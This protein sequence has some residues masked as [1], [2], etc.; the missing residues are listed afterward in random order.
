MK[1]ISFTIFL[2]SNFRKFL[3]NC[4]LHEKNGWNH[5]TLYEQSVVECFFV[6]T[7]TLDTTRTGL[8]RTCGRLRKGLVRPYIFRTTMHSPGDLEPFCKPYS[9]CKRLST[10]GL[11]GWRLTRGT[12][13]WSRKIEIEKKEMP[14]Y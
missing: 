1:V 12:M 13:S 3:I 8:S 5:L 4:L 10:A 14:S 11:S 6:F 7:I 9:Y 2:L